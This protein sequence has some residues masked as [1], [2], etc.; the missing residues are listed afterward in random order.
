M[1]NNYVITSLTPNTQG[2]YLLLGTVNGTPVQVSFS[3]STAQA[4]NALATAV[5]FQNFVAPLMLAA[6]PADLSLYQSL[7][8]SQ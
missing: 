4:R 8:W 6:V 7:S 2:G 1:A 3:T 5:G